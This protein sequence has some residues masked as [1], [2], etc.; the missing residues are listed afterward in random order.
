VPGR[1]FLGLDWRAGGLSAPAA[2]T[3]AVLEDWLG[4]AR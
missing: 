1:L 4:R 3:D 2:D